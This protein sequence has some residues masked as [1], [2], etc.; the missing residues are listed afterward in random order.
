MMEKHNVFWSIIFFFCI[1]LTGNAQER[2]A[3]ALDSVSRIM[4]FHI[5]YPV[6]TTEVH[7]DYM[8]NS[9][10]LQKIKDYLRYSHRI[11]SMVIYSYASP[12]G[13]YTYNKLLARSVELVPRNTFYNKYQQKGISMNR[14]LS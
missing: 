7:E 1:V 14:L 12:E 5:Y 10:N 3:N 4:H 11:D 2:N 13:S 6:N 9:K 8:D